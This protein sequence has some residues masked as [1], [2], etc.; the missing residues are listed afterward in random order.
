MRCEWHNGFLL[1][2]ELVGGFCVVYFGEFHLR[3]VGMAGLCNIGMCGNYAL[4]SRA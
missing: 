1:D 2:I 4:C 3:D